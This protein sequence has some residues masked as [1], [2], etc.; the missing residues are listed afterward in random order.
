MMMNCSFLANQFFLLKTLRPVRAAARALARGV[1]IVA[2]LF[3]AQILAAQE[4]ICDTM[5][6]IPP[7]LEEPAAPNCSTDTP[8]E[9]WGSANGIGKASVSALYPS[10]PYPVVI[11]NM[12]IKISGTFTVD[13]SIRFEKCNV[14]FDENATMITSG[15]VVLE[16]FDCFFTNCVD[17]TWE[18]IQIRANGA[19]RFQTCRIEGALYGIVFSKDY[20]AAESTLIDNRFRRNYH[21]IVSVEEGT[22]LYFTDFVNNSFYGGSAL[23]G[24]P[25][26][27][28]HSGIRLAGCNA[29][30]GTPFFYS[31]PNHYT[32]YSNDFSH[33]RAGIEVYGSTTT[34][35]I[36]NCYFTFM[37][38]QPTSSGIL[39]GCG[40]NAIGSTLNVSAYYEPV[41]DRV[42]GECIFRFCASAGIR[43]SQTMLNV[44]QAVFGDEQIY[45]IAS[46][47]TDFRPQTI[48]N[49]D[50][51]KVGGFNLARAGIY[52]ERPNGSGRFYSTIINKNKFDPVLNTVSPIAAIDIRCPVPSTDHMSV[53]D[54]TI[55]VQNSFLDNP[56]YGIV[57]YGNQSSNIELKANRINMF[58]TPQGSE[59]TFGIFMTDMEG[60]WNRLDGNDA[61][62][63]AQCNYHL[64]KARNVRYCDNISNGG[65]NGFHFYGN[66]DNANW[67]TNEVGTHDNGL[68]IG[69]IPNPNGPPLSSGMISEQ[70]RRGNLWDADG[71]QYS[72]KAAKCTADSDLSEFL[73]EDN[74]PEK[75]PTKIDPVNGW[76][77]LVTG[78][79]EHCHGTT[80]GISGFEDSLAAGGGQ[81][82]IS[83]AE[84]WEATRLLMETLLRDPG[85]LTGDTTMQ[86]FYT[87][88][89]TSS[90]GQFAQ[91]NQM[92]A[93]GGFSTNPLWDVREAKAVQ[94]Q[95]AKV[96][97]DSLNTRTTLSDLANNIFIPADSMLPVVHA[98]MAVL[99]DS[100]R[101]I[102]DVLSA[103]HDTVLNQALLELDSITITEDYEQAY[104]T[105]ITYQIKIAL[106]DEPEEAGYDDLMDVANADEADYG[107]AVRHARHYLSDCERY[108][109]IAPD[110]S[111]EEER[112]LAASAPTSA[113]VVSIVPNPATSS[114]RVT[115]ERL[116]AGAWSIVSSTGALTR[117][118]T[119]PEG[120]ASQQ[121]SLEDF[122]PGAY[123]F[124]VR[125]NSGVTVVQKLMVLR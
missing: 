17:K 3:S 10:G 12:N 16:G 8:H 41:A 55:E 53:N 88:N 75:K 6:T 89:L 111:E 52:L 98:Q 66:N 122:A 21:S 92:V 9:F 79:I 125:S 57:V 60:V 106:G 109:R 71:N 29:I 40:I 120:Q 5:T 114:I 82:S 123:Y 65:V 85:Q 117:T 38:P 22:Q 24:S 46:R 33:L 43:A 28:P 113:P 30:I 48:E 84:R 78:T 36:S 67:S 95:A 14:L 91:I 110:E 108:F 18:S 107:G 69:H 102:E 68:L 115:Q 37:R 13:E 35:H 86:A 44:N 63:G 50:F 20:R 121:I 56:C 26:T 80:R 93:E 42:Y 105:L 25:G 87:Q 64:E 74:S 73:I 101:I 72:D 103:I 81:L 94:Y 116:G 83:D 97:L 118:G 100:I 47:R 96:I 11:T 90:A 34:A 62:G 45:G 112:P 19:I 124:Q 119:W 15:T 23:P 70:T 58:T 59:K 7:T 4:E 32:M 1:P 54:N 99:A 49:C 39:T 61:T 76:F 2:L 51:D 104:K 77:S 31:D 27:L